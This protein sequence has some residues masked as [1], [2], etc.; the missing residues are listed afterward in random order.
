M[1]ITCGMTNTVVPSFRSTR[2]LDVN[3]PT[4]AREPFPCSFLRREASA[5]PGCGGLPPLPYEYLPSPPLPPPPPDTAPRR[6]TPSLSPVPPPL[7]FISEDEGTAEGFPIPAILEPM[8]NLGK[9]L[10]L[11]KLGL[12]AA[13]RR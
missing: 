5:S 8:V 2:A 1:K 3:V 13:S 7:P 10:R 4:A 6:P 12:E 11:M 9:P